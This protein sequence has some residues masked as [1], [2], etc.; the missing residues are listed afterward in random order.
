MRVSM[1][2]IKITR[3]VALSGFNLVRFKEMVYATN[4]QISC[5]AESNES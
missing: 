4:H 2:I 1:V 5:K 3:V